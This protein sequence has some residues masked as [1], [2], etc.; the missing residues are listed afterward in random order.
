MAR[1]ESYW[2]SGVGATYIETISPSGYDILINGTNK[3]LNFGS[4]VGSSGYGF[5]DNNG[6]IETKNSGG[7]WAGIGGG[8]SGDMILASAQTNTGIKTFLDTTMKLRN[9]ANTFDGVFVNT[10]TANRIYTLPNK[11]MTIAGTN[12]KLS[13][14]AATTSLE[15]IGVISDET[16]TGLLVFGT[17]P[18]ITNPAISAINPTAEVHSPAGAGTATMDLAVANQHEITMPAGN[19]TIALSNATLSKIFMISI[20]QDGTGSRT[21][22]W[23]IT[24]KW[25]GGTVP[26]LTTTANK[27][28]TFGFKRT[29]VDTYDGFILGANI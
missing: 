4:V 7:A 26:T 9:V 1:T 15:F 24:I 10:N 25:A 14:F 20:T 23:F 21:V 2:Q 11:A 3:Y 5:R 29:G 18:T 19:I 8:G 6:T 22:T 16:G 13:V 28:D 17:A 12:D 27:R